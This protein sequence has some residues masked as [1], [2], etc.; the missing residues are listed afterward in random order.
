MD[1]ESTHNSPLIYQNPCKNFQGHIC[2]MPKAPTKAPHIAASTRKARTLKPYTSKPGPKGKQSH[3][4]PLTSAKASVSN[5]RDNLT[6]Y[7]WLSIFAYIDRH[8][9]LGQAAIVMHF[10]TRKEGSLTFSQSALSRNLR[11]CREFEDC[12]KTTPN[13][14][15]SKRVRVVTRPDVERALFLW[16]RHME[17]KGENING[18]MLLEKRKKFEQDLQVPEEQCLTGA[19]WVAPFCKA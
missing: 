8:P 1:G 12:A 3:D 15:S 9:G 11:R 14:L 10:K 5:T 17:E 18:P 19:G 13:A 7:D 6:L 16:V 4:A 2:T